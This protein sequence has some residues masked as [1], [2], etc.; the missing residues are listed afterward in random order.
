MNM[1]PTMEVRWF[2]RAAAPADVERWF[3]DAELPPEC[4]ARRVDHYLGAL[5]GDALSITKHIA[6]AT[7]PVRQILFMARAPSS[8][9]VA[10]RIFTTVYECGIV[11]QTRTAITPGSQQWRRV[12]LVASACRT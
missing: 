10:D 2:G 3:L 1:Q 5:P 12:A 6:K 8:R 11:R 4:E 9:H 7:I